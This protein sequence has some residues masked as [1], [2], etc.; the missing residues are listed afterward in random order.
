MV[1]YASLFI[2]KFSNFL[3]S[4]EHL[5]GNTHKSGILP[6]VLVYQ[7]FVISICNLKKRKEIKT[8]CVQ[9]KTAVF[10]KNCCVKW[11]RELD[12]TMNMCILKQYKKRG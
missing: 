5:H 11:T 9:Q 1:I 8:N 12:Q 2:T 7:M 10:Q 4:F 3:G 6:E